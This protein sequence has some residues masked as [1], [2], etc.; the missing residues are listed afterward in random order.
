MR[1]A[2]KPNV[3][4]RITSSLFNGSSRLEPVLQSEAAECGLA[5]LTMIARYHGHEV[6]LN[7]LRR[8]YGSS[9]KGSSLAHLIATGRNLG[10]DARALRA[11]MGYISRLK[12]P[13]FLHWDLNHFVVLEQ[14]D[15]RGAHILDPANGA[16]LLP[17]Q[18]VGKHFTG[19]ALELAP[20]ANFEP[21]KDVEHVR[22]RTLTGRM[23]GLGKV[24]L[25][26]LGLSVGI[27]ALSL[28]L[29]FQMQW[30]V[31]RALISADRNLL[32]IICLAFFVVVL[33][34]SGLMFMRA[35]VISWVGAVLSEKWTINLFSHL[36]RLPLDFFEKRHIGDMVSRFTSLSQIQQTLTGSFVEALL[37]GVVGLL[38]LLVLISYDIYLALVVLVSAGLYA[39]LRLIMYK[40]LWRNNEEQLIY[41]ARQQSELM[42]SVRG[43]QAIKLAN[44]QADRVLR[45]ANLT[46]ET[47]LRAM[48]SQRIGLAFTAIN[49]GVFGIQRVVIVTIGAHMVL[50][51]GFTAGM[52]VAFLAFADQLTHKVG[53]VIDKTIDLKMLRLHMQRIGDIALAQPEQESFSSFHKLSKEPSVA[54]RNLSF[55]Y[56]DSEPWIFRNLDLK[57][58]AGESLAII[59][60]SGC[61][62]STLAKIIL[63]LLK[64]T[65]GSV[66]VDGVNIERIGM[67]R[68]RDEV[69]AAVMQ[70]DQLF[71][72][73]IA[74]N[75]AFGDMD[76]S[77]EKIIGA[78]VMAEIHDD[79]VAMPMGYESLVG[80]MGSSLSGGQ[81][82]RVIFA[83]AMYRKPRILLLDEATSHLDV[84][85]EGKINLAVKRI[86]AT[87]IIIAH[88]KETIESADRI[89]DM[90]KSLRNSSQVA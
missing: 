10:F 24:F 87:R 85:R 23:R 34:Q 18:D 36:M 84:D 35:W 60:P 78:A 82:Q 56:S 77:M 17:L 12:M 44:R 80:D 51:G 73:S 50:K 47:V 21:I 76:A 54:I 8:R 71:G 53:G 52:L 33:A 81:K 27:E 86:K 65:Q 79:V 83:R 6:D 58:K 4:D 43:V 42:E 20:S 64:P 11:E 30:V 22:L 1:Q 41:G 31:D 13:C 88:R 89:F 2:R 59:G 46:Q 14:V 61:G 3:K 63:G 69:I 62:K 16:R 72:G 74:E 67:T 37:D 70:N 49:Q 45:L 39:M 26:I 90:G 15:R 5:C 68:Y 55:R 9:L 29:P 38:A 66:E 57:I 32:P 19:V 48:R 40:Y 25:Q 75:I 28:L 7:S